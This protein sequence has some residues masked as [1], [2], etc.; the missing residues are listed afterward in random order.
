MLLETGSMLV[1]SLQK[2]T[3]ICTFQKNVLPDAALFAYFTDT[4]HLKSNIFLKLRQ[5]LN[6]TNAPGAFCDKKTGRWTRLEGWCST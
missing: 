1:G 6:R 4:L 3:G 2:Y 5:S